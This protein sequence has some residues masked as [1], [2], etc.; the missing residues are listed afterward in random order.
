[1]SSTTHCWCKWQKANVKCN[2][3]ACLFELSCDLML[4]DH[5]NTSVNPGFEF[6]A[7]QHW[8]FLLLWQQHESKKCKHSDLVW[9]NACKPAGSNSKFCPRL[10]WNDFHA[11]TWFC[12]AFSNPAFHPLADHVTRNGASAQIKFHPNFIHVS[13][14]FHLVFFPEKWTEKWNMDNPTK[15]SF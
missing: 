1:M 9:N 14:K 2:C 8:L 11:W 12:A 7:S 4:S 3:I 10:A 5:S 6:F 15:V 13:F